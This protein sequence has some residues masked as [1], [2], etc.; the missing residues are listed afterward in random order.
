M[1]NSD[2]GGNNSK[3]R[4]DDEQPRKK[5]VQR[6]REQKQMEAKKVS[7]KGTWQQG[8]TISHTHEQAEEE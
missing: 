1:T 4:K 5:G 7:D 2:N 8:K 6:A 3:V